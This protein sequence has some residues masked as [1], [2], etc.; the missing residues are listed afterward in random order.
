MSLQYTYGGL[1]L[2]P[3]DTV[4]FYCY[5]IHDTE[6]DRFY[7]GSR[8][9]D[10]R[11]THDLLESYFT[12]STVVDFVQRLRES[13]SLFDFKV[14]YFHTR[15]A[16]FA[17]E[18]A[19][20]ARYNVAA[21][22]RFYNAMN[23][24]GSNCGAGTVLCKNT[25]GGTYR[26]STEEYA[27]GNHKHVATGRQIVRLKNDPTKTLSILTDDFDPEIH[28]TQFAG[29]VLCKDVISGKNAKVPREV[30]VAQS[31]R[32][33]PIT[34]G[35]ATYF[36]TASQCYVKHPINEPVPGTYQG[37]TKG[38]VPA[39]DEN[40]EIRMVSKDELRTN[41]NLSHPNKGFTTVY[42]LKRHEL[43][44]VQRDELAH[45]PHL[46]NRSVKVIFQLDGR[47][48][49]SMKK[50][51]EYYTQ[52]YNKTIPYTIKASNAQAFDANILVI[53]REHFTWK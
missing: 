21:D 40:G 34:I 44:R 13:P 3:N 52:V 36:D 12:S 42:D 5:T 49:T 32:Y 43:V 11:A 15:A 4:A 38:M 37:A 22:P 10:G 17:A 53:Q 18:A 26:V 31:E 2:N 30:L 7:S 39:R 9:V 14:E 8:G 33:K 23:A 25:L 28:V 1:A 19:Y 24:Q 16:A 45:S 48:F 41:P 50:L 20:H 47:Y 51:R 27:T 6:Y 35:Y 29:Y 46:I